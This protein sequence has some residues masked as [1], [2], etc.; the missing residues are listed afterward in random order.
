MIVCTRCTAGPRCFFVFRRSEWS[1]ELCENAVQVTVVLP[2]A[3]GSST[4]LRVQTPFVSQSY[5]DLPSLRTPV[6]VTLSPPVVGA[7]NV[8]EASQLAPALTSMLAAQLMVAGFV[9]V[10]STVT[11]KHSFRRPWPN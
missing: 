7:A 2:A 1:G 5:N 4:V 10:S 9:P 8:T 11:V 6:T 3:N